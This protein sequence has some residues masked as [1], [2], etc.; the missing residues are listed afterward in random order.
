MKNKCLYSE[1]TTAVEAIAAALRKFDGETV[2]CIVSVCT[3]DSEKDAEE[4]PDFYGIYV[5]TF[6]ED[7][8]R[9]EVIIGEH[10]Y[11][12][13]GDDGGIIRTERHPEGNGDDTQG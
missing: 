10:G 2:N 5:N 13:R 11:L 4:K 8:T 6:N 9:T 7:K 3:R 1:I 12:Y